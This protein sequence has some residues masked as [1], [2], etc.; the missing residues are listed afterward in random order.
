VPPGHREIELRP[1][2]VQVGIQD[3]RHLEPLAL[4]KHCAQTPCP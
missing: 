2:V 4:P 1:E 3:F